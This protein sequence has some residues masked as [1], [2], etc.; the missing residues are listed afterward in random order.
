MAR[1]KRFIGIVLGAALVAGAVGVAMRLAP[2][3]HPSNAQQVN[4]TDGQPLISRGYTDAPTGTVII[5]GD[6]AGGSAVLELRIKDGQTVK[7]DEIIAVLSNYP[8]AEIGVRTAE[9][10]LEKLRQVRKTVLLGTRATEIAL[11]EAD[12]KSSIDQNR[13]NALQRQRSGKPIDQKEME[14]KLDEMHFENQKASLELAKRSLAIDLSMNQIDI[15]NA[16]ARV[17]TARRDREAALV[18]SPIDG[19]VVDIFTRQGE[20]LQGRL[21]IAKIVDM[22]QM[23]VLA[24]V[25]ELHLGR[26]VPGARVEVTF[27]G[28]KRVYTG[29]VV[30]AP[31]M[32]TRVKRSKADMGL[33]TAHTVEAEIQFDD[34][35]SIPQ[36][37]DHEARVTFL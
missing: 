8:A 5:A 12:I 1:A 36:L 4:Q 30:R 25:D 10:N 14:Q 3:Q 19:V 37:L 13:L 20:T 16:E 15:A 29:T 27:R 22:R 17:E 11:Q 28:D 7:R 2:S 23:R 31:M 35:T 24:D 9:S 34:P 6:P 33:G 21:G 26:L 18:R 32:V